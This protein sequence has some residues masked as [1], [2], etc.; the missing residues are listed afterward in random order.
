[1]LVYRDGVERTGS[2]LF[3]L[4]LGAPGSP[5]ELFRSTTLIESGEISP[6]GRWIAFEARESGNETNIFVRPFPLTNTGNWQVSTGG[7][8]RPMWSRNGRELFYRSARDFLSVAVTSPPG[9]SAF[10]Y[11]AAKVL[12]PFTPYF[13]NTPRTYDI[14]LDGRQFLMVKPSTP[15]MGPP[16]SVTVVTNW[17]EELRAR[18]K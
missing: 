14:S 9:V 8:W 16:S 3:V 7:G 1:L 12:F 13:F 6:D 2:G 18:V 10:T 5:K 17:F 15:Q 4:P 11:S